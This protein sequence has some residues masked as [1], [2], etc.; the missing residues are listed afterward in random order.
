MLFSVENLFNISKIHRL[1][2]EFPHQQLCKINLKLHKIYNFKLLELSS[3]ENI[4]KIFVSIFISCISKDKLSRS[5]VDN[6]LIFSF[7]SAVAAEKFS[8]KS[9][10]FEKIFLT[11]DAGNPLSVIEAE[12]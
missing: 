12:C 6:L 3:I 8:L 2:A 9:S 5:F 4:F 1:I 7:T 10:E 11:H